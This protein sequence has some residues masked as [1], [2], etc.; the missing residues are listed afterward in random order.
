MKLELSSEK[1]LNWF[2]KKKSILILYVI[3]SGL[4]ERTCG[5]ISFKHNNFFNFF[6]CFPP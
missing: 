6:F 5:I 1:D 4:D 2:F 3:D